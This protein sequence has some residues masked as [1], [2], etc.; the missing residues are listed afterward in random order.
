MLG[1]ISGYYAAGQFNNVLA[2]GSDFF[3]VKN[4]RIYS[5]F[6]FHDIFYIPPSVSYCTGGQAGDTFPYESGF[7]NIKDFYE[8]F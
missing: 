5:L 8:H 4:S 3:N 7:F 6:F 2:D 1:L